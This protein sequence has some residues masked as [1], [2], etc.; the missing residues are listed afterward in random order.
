MPI[1]GCI[2]QSDVLLRIVVLKNLSTYAYLGDY[3]FLLSGLS[4]QSALMFVC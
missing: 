2:V 3:E 4:R 1:S